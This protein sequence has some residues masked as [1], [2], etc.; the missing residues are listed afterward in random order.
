[1]GAALVLVDAGTIRGMDTPGERLKKARELAGLGMRELARELMKIDPKK[2]SESGLAS[3]ISKI[4]A[5][6]I[7]A[8]NIQIVG[9][10]AQHFGLSLDWIERGEG[11]GP[12]YV[13]PRANN[14]YICFRLRDI[15]RDAPTK[16]LPQIAKD[17]GV[18][19]DH[20]RALIGGHPLDPAAFGQWATFFIKADR[21]K[22]TDKLTAIVENWWRIEGAENAAI[23]DD[24]NTDKNLV[25][26]QW[27][28][29]ARGHGMSRWSALNVIEEQRNFRKNIDP[30]HWGT[31][32]LNEAVRS[33]TRDEAEREAIESLGKNKTRLRTLINQ[34]TESAEKARSARSA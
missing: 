11:L 26:Q 34:L 17:V 29:L 13:P 19:V 10:L 4:E 25:R 12:D 3:M 21:E 7:D 28:F 27:L 16:T 22:S 33:K 32:F 23:V 8:R 31:A 14:E 15:Q 5:N 1:M 30:V 24:P 9:W 20:I 18:D 2:R 6:K